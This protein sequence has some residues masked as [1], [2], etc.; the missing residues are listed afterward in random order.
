VKLM[1]ILPFAKCR[2]DGNCLKCPFRGKAIVY[3]PFKSHRRGVSIGIN[4]FPCRKVCSFNCVYCFRGFTEVKTL[5]HTIPPYS[6]SHAILREAL[7]KA[8][9]TLGNVNA[10]DFSGS[11]EPTLHP[12]LK[13]YINTVKEFVKERSL[14]VSIGIFTNST[15]LFKNSIVK[16]LKELDHVEAKLDTVIE[17]KFRVINK[18]HKLLTTKKIIEGL[19]NFRKVFEGTL[20]I[21]IMLLKYNKVSNYGLKD[22]R[23]IGETL[24]TIEPDIVHIYVPYRTPRLPSVSKP[25]KQKAVEFSKTLRE[26]GLKVKLFT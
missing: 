21:Q 24:L 1:K 20:A 25:S 3:G 10:I 23:L 22:A 9:N 19:F 12:K 14:N 16:V 2:L 17:W 15:T 26:Y 18:P 5:K 13:S 11:G 4:L 6:F 7:E 8:V